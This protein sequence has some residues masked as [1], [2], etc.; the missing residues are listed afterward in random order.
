MIFPD[1]VK[2]STRLA[3]AHMFRGKFDRISAI[4]EDRNDGCCL[5]HA[6]NTT[7]GSNQMT[8]ASE[9]IAFVINTESIHTK[10]LLL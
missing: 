5:V 3:P 9:I 7:D 8:V 10:G 6:I 4:N 2:Y 1:L